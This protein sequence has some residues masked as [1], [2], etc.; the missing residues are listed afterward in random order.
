MN[1]VRVVLS[2]AVAVLLALALASPALEA[3]TATIRGTVTDSATQGALQG[4]LVTVLGGWAR[5]ETN[6]SGQ[7]ALHGIAPGT[8]RVRVQL[9]GY[10]PAE[11]ELTVADSTDATVDFVLVPGVAKLE[12][13]VAV[14]YGT[15]LRADLSSSVSSVSGADL[16]GQPIASVDG[17]LQGKAPGV[18]VIQNAGNPGNGNR[19]KPGREQEDQGT[20][21][22][23]L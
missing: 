3:Q 9:I 7:Y 4:A 18:Q 23:K 11:R 5:A 1:R 12:E 14:G 2:V 17:A 8:V 16:V 19:A 10:T 6:Q 13:V 21:N 20:R 22:W 15:Q